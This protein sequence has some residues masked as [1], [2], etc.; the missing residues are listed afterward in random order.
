MAHARSDKGC[1]GDEGRVRGEAVVCVQLEDAA[2]LP[3]CKQGFDQ[4]HGVGRVPRD[5][6]PRLFRVRG[7]AAV[8]TTSR[9][10]IVFTRSVS[11]IDCIT[12]RDVGPY[13]KRLV[14]GTM[15]RR[16]LMLKPK[17]EWH[18]CGSMVR[19]HPSRR[20]RVGGR[21]GRQPRGVDRGWASCP[22]GV[23]RHGGGLSRHADPGR[24]RERL[25]AILAEARTASQDDLDR[26]AAEA[27][28]LVRCCPYPRRARKRSGF[29]VRAPWRSCPRGRALFRYR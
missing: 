19:G 14:P 8:R 1:L 15:E 18:A 29:R 4:C 2:P 20:C 12:N 6:D 21:Q 27:K 25:S 17:R 5:D 28:D 23:R 16:S 26:L 9:K 22:A 13:R 10:V 24:V 11:Q 3:G 7:R